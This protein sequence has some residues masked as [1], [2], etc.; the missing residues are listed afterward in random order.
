M[1]FFRT[2]TA[3]LLIWSLF[4]APAGWAAEF[5]STGF[6][7]TD[8]NSSYPQLEDPDSAFTVAEGSYLLGGGNVTRLENGG[9]G[10][11]VH[12]VLTTAADYNSTDFVYEIALQNS[13]EGISFVG[14]GSGDKN[15]TDANWPAA[16]VYWIV[17]DNA[18]KF[19]YMSNPSEQPDIISP[20][21][22]DVPYRA[23]ITKLG[24]HLYFQ[25]DK[26]NDGTFDYEQDLSEEQFD[27]LN[28]AG[29]SRLFFGTAYVQREF[30]DMSVARMGDLDDDG[31]LTAADT[32][33]WITALTN[34]SQ[35]VTAHE[36][37]SLLGR[38]DLDHNGVFDLADLRRFEE[39]LAESAAA[40]VV[41]E[42]ASASLLFVGWAVIL[43]DLVGRRLRQR[44]T[45]R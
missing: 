13:G 40:A 28:E 2:L 7:E 44:C 39:V 5:F 9:G 3:A 35:Y 4:L 30:D 33:A 11:D 12:Y 41:P 31:L 21:A 24:D 42:P 36:G 8:L 16:A 29:N 25:L 1:L 45:P 22:Q 15:S 18:I 6:D 19:D 32:A 37:V 20:T 14:V 10:L 27:F 26:G 38:G 43:L 17:Q 23:R 34:P